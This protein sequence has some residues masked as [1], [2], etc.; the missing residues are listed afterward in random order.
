MSSIAPGAPG[1]P[2]GASLWHQMPA[3]GRAFVRF[4]GGCTALAGLV[5]ITLQIMGPPHSAVVGQDIDVG[6]ASDAATAAAIANKTDIPVPQPDMLE[7]ETGPGGFALPKRGLHGR[8]ARQVYAAPVVPVPAGMAQVALLI[9]GVG[10]SDALSDEAIDSL[11]GPVSLAVS[12]YASDAESLMER[13]R[14]HK[15]ETLVS[16]PIQGSTTGGKA[17]SGDAGP[18]ALG[19]SLSAQKNSDNLNWALSHLAGYAGVTNAFSGQNGGDYPHSPAFT[20]ILSALDQRGLFYLNA[21][22][23]TP[24]NGPGA[25]GTADVA[26]NTDADIVTIDIQ[27]LKL[28]QA[29][30]K[31]GRAIGI[32]GPL[33]PVALA[34]LRAW[35]PHLKDVGITLVPVS[36]L[37]APQQPAPPTQGASTPSQP[38]A[39]NGAMHVHVTSPDMGRQNQQPSS[40]GLP[41]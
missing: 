26:I 17:A 27:L 29:A 9:D 6:G 7:S 38:T 1:L 12:P 33:R 39:A 30:R 8:M 41:Q 31:N 35:I 22:P 36:M 28:Q 32:I 24:S 10:Q 14:T 16:L 11:P 3:S 2:S 4:W 13:A 19:A 23:G 37:V 20:P 5:A 21:T 34:C 40:F 15:H 25:V 18:N